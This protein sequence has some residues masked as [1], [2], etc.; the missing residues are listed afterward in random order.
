MKFSKDQK[1]ELLMVDSTFCIFPW[2]HLYVEA[3]GMTMPCC[4]TIEDFEYPSTV[5][6]TLAELFNSDMWKQLRLDMLSGKKAKMCSKCYDVEKVGNYSYR[7]YANSEFGKFIDVIDNTLESGEVTEFNLRYIDVRFS[8]KCN[9]ACASCGDK[10]STAWIN[11]INNNGMYTSKHIPENIIDNSKEDIIAQLRPHLKTSH[12]VYFAGGEP[13]IMPE[14]YAMLE[15]LTAQEVF[16]V[17]LRYNSN[18][19]TLTY[20]GKNIVDYWKQMHNVEIGASIDAIGHRAE[21]IRYGT[22]WDNVEQNIKTLLQYD[23]IVL[24]YD[25]VIS[26]LNIDHLPELYEYLFDNDLVKDNTFFSFNLAFTPSAFS[27]TSLPVKIKEKLAI[28]LQNWTNKFKDKHCHNLKKI[29]KVIEICNQIENIINFMNSKDTWNRESLKFKLYETI[30][31]YQKNW[32]N[33]LTMLYS[34]SNTETLIL[35]EFN[36]NFCI[37]PWVHM[38]IWQTGDS[39]PC[40]IY[41]WQTPTGNINELGLKGAWNSKD[42]RALRLQ[43]LNG[44]QPVGCHKCYNYE[45]QGITSYRYK[46]NKDFAHHK[47]LVYT[48]NDDGSVDKLNIAYFDVRFSNLCN[49]KCRTCGAHFSNQWGIEEK[50]PHPLI[51]IE[52][53]ELW[54]DIEELLP[55]IEEV[56][57]TGGE[58]LIMEQHYRLLKMLIKR[59][60]D[61]VLTYNSNATVLQYKGIEI[62]EYW[63]RFSKINYYIS[64]DQLDKKAEYTRHGVGWQTFCKNLFHMRDTMPNVSMNPNPTISVLNIMDLADIIRFCFDNKLA[65]NYQIHLNNLLITPEYFS[66]TILPGHLKRLAEINMINLIN[67]LDSYVDMPENE[68]HT[69]IDNL[70]NIIAFMYEN[71]DTD[72]IPKFKEEIR[73][74]DKLRNVNFSSTFPELKELYD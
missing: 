19:S 61:P 23:N 32:E 9:Y 36:K 51:E 46:M 70:N 26:I 45:K 29:N 38:S 1:N 64:F 53:T 12:Q 72:R 66:C 56:Y 20:K 27:L 68:K 39:Y 73:K 3:S 21:V 47:E 10:F 28:D 22:K 7:K 15:E 18:L 25:T 42:Q 5:D 16:D 58:S 74:I 62:N 55:N 44:E 34:L 57:F 17:K 63:Q 69:L 37:A 35:E 13:L 52:Y 67:D 48:T 41:N 50:K 60:L 40:C 71:D 33:E 31:A 6:N 59:N 65:K 11:M 24:K 8:N 54:D 49:L 43:L 2:I 30:G 14:H 4:N